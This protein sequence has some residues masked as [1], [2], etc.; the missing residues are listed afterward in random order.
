MK[1]TKDRKEKEGAK[2]FSVA[3]MT[4]HRGKQNYVRVEGVNDFV[5]AKHQARRFKHDH[6][7][8]R[9]Q[10]VRGVAGHQEGLGVVQYTRQILS[11]H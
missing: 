11:Q 6:D 9:A 1:R 8:N 2:N 5:D 10:L 3:L 7:A 4:V